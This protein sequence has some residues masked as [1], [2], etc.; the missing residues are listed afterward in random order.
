MVLNVSNQT[1]KQ[2]VLALMAGLPGVG[3]TT[4]AKY[5]EGT[6]SWNVIDKDTI[7]DVLL[8]TVH[9]SE[10]QAGRAAFEVAFGLLKDALIS[11][12]SA[13][14]DSSALHP[15]IVDGALRLCDELR[16]EPGM[17]IQ[18]KVVLCE[19]DN[20]IR[21][22]RLQTRRQRSSQRR[23]NTIHA[24][25]YQCFDHLPPDKLTL[26][27]EDKLETYA[28]RAANYLTARNT[29]HFSLPNFSSTTRFFTSSVL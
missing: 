7:K 13:I 26:C 16:H 21:Q 12:H 1:L 5:L 28:D 6:L 22:H 27:T 20:E 14:L 9:I 11:G 19:V 18:L 4:L 2:P 3:K 10:E 8:D 23:S 15:F 29:S 25:E 17:Q 24:D